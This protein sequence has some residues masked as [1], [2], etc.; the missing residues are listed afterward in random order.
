MKNEKCRELRD[1]KTTKETDKLTSSLSEKSRLKSRATTHLYGEPN[2]PTL[3]EHE[4]QEG[5]PR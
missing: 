5:A 3:R 4:N 1:T 2:V